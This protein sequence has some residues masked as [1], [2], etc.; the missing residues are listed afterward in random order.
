[1]HIITEITEDTVK[2]NYLEAGLCFIYGKDR[3]GKAMFVIKCK[4]YTKGGK[5]FEELQKLVVYW[6]ERLERY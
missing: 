2:R 4:L 1:M 5:D 3:D 6:F